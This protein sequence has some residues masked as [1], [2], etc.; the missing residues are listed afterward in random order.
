MGTN[1]KLKTGVKLWGKDAERERNLANTNLYVPETTSFSQHFGQVIILST[2]DRELM[3]HS[4]CPWGA[5]ER[6]KGDMSTCCS[7]YSHM[8]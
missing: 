8:I 7:S 1:I 5:E 4:P 3:S 6:L 2:Q